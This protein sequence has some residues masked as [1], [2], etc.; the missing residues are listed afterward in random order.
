MFLSHM[1]GARNE[2]SNR[3]PRTAT[4]ACGVIWR[5]STLH[6]LDVDS[7]APAPEL[8]EKLSLQLYA[9]LLY[10]NPPCQP[11][12]ALLESP[13][14]Q[15]EPEFARSGSLQRLRL[16]TLCIPRSYRC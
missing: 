9:L 16:R 10:L 1:A 12:A 3:R 7:S 15:P 4:A 13:R 14:P 2:Y 8:L 11:F 5:S 6:R